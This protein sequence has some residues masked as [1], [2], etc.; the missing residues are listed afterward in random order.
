MSSDY[1]F[2]EDVQEY[3]DDM[4]EDNEDVIHE[5]EG[6]CLLVASLKATRSQT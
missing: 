2:S 6:A 5:D 4:D 1:E 3:Y